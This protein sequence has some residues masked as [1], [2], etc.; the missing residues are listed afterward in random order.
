M[1]KIT[2]KHTIYSLTVKASGYSMY[3]FICPG[4]TLVLRKIPFD[5]VA[6]T[7]VISVPFVRLINIQK[8]QFAF[9]THRAFRKDRKT[10]YT[11]GDNNEHIDQ[12]TIDQSMNIY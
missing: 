1:R 4:M 5:K 11:K 10:I 9:I 8:Q 2:V 6:V 3:P 7:D 12:D